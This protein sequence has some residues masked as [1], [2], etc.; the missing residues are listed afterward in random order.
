M[1]KL[2]AVLACVLLL[3]ALFTGCSSG[4]K[5]YNSSAAYDL[6]GAPQSPV[7]GGSGKTEQGVMD[8]ASQNADITALPDGLNRKII[9]YVSLGAETTDFDSF[10]A[11]L[12]E[13]VGTAGG[14]M[15]SSSVS[16]DSARSN[17]YAQLT[18]RV[19]SAKLDAFLTQVGELG[20]ITYSNRSSE[21]I[22]LEYSDLEGKIAM[23]QAQQKRLLELIDSAQDIDALIQLE[24]RLAEISYQ[25]DSY[26]STQ[27][28]YDSLIDYSSVTIHVD[29]VQRVTTIHDQTIGQ[30]IAAGWS[31]T[32]YSIKNGA[33]ELFV[34]F[35]VNL[36]YILVLAAVGFVVVFFTI[37]SNKKRAQ[38]RKAYYPA[39][40]AAGFTPP[41]PKHINNQ[42][43]AQNTKEPKDK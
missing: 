27:N 9:W 12:T 4:S 22:T 20:T 32:W 39:P 5:S 16:G 25:I 36:P 3:A 34:W 8:E 18:V 43:P 38:K 24:S 26:K 42:P 1:K 37:K 15:E 29:E 19:P 21:D 7:T 11:G 40:P 23:L 33:T 14:Y 41:A 17:R 28:R 35:V 2:W 10:I 13:C 6:A 30:R 31:D